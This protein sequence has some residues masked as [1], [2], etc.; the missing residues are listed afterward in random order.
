[1]AILPPTMFKGLGLKLRF[2]ALSELTFTIYEYVTINGESSLNPSYDLIKKNRLISVPEIGWFVIAEVSEDMDGVTNLK[3]VTCNSYEYV[4]NAKCINIT[5][6]TYKLY[7]ALNPND[8]TT[9]LGKI[10]AQMPNWSIGYVSSSLYNKYRTFELPSTTIYGFLM[11][12]AEAAYECI[13]DFDTINEQIRVYD[14]T[15]VVEQT[16]IVFTFDNLLKTANVKEVSDDII[17]ALA[18]Y[19]A[20][21]LDIRNVNPIG[22]AFLYN[23][24][25]YMTTDWMT[26]GLIDKLTTWQAKV[27]ADTVT[28]ATN[29]ASLKTKNNELLQL[30]TEKTNLEGQL[31]A[32]EQVRQVKL[33]SQ[34]PEE[35]ADLARVTGEINTKQGEIDAKQAEI[36]A[37]QA[38]ITTVNNSLQSIHDDL[39]F[40]NN[41]TTSEL[42]ELSKFTFEGTFQN[43]NYVQTD[44]M[45]PAEVQDMSL[46]L[47][48][49]GKKTL[50]KLSQ[51]MYSFSMDALSF[52]LNKDYT[53]FISDL[54]LGCLV[55]AEIKEGD[56]TTPILLEM[57][58]EYDNPDNFTMTFGNRFRLDSAE[59]TFAELYN[60]QA[61]SSANVN[62]Y[63]NMWG[64]PVKSGLVDEV[65][66]YMND[67]LSLAN[68]SIISSN[69]EDI[70]IADFGIRGAKVENGQ[71]SNN[72]IWI[73]H[74]LICMT[75]D[76]WQT[77]K[78]AIGVSEE[79]K[80]FVNANVLAGNLV[81]GNE[82]IITNE[83]NNLTVDGNGLVIHNG[84]TKFTANPND[85]NVIAIQKNI[86]TAS[87][88]DWENQFYT[89]ANG[90]A[91][92]KGKVQIQNDDVQIILD[93]NVTEN[94]LSISKNTGTTLAP[95]WQKSMYVTNDGTL[96]VGGWS[97]S[98]EGLES[99]AG[100]KIMSDGTGK[101]SLLTYT[102]NSAT[103]NGNIYASNLSDYITNSNIEDNSI[104]DSKLSATYQNWKSSV[105]VTANSAGATASMIVQN[106]GDNS[107]VTPATVI[108][109]INTDGSSVKI[110]ADKLELSG[111]AT[112]TSLTQEGESSIN[113]GNI[114]T[115]TLS[116]DRINFSNTGA[117]Q[118]TGTWT[119]STATY[120]T[121]NSLWLRSG[122]SASDIITIQHGTGDSSG[123]IW[124]YSNSAGLRAPGSGDGLRVTSSAV[125]FNGQS[126]SATAKFV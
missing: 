29:L 10:I 59:W 81:A 82:L 2:N 32:L 67:N 102:T 74:N 63:S 98:D 33:P 9:L 96:K 114:V 7:N 35:I 64:K 113:G 109:K 123:M 42:L 73:S 3:N 100:D 54:K 14:T 60:Q 85:T 117:L 17:T 15:D 120:L 116:A 40:T 65:S 18:V 58:I 31:K 49:Q 45:T 13:F 108:A 28:Y 61:I 77:S 111:Y 37:K 122:D 79:G 106:I 43:S 20:D 56:W 97:I 91:F 34:T 11:S 121:G 55:N 21:D 4:F 66:N 112:F 5:D 93:P 19:G 89:D 80:S 90:N 12:T 72:Q 69:G 47:L 70:E 50:E 75:D 110:S 101:I 118:V 95:V 26:Q 46:Q 6:G 1:M 124:L 36:T 38:E 16:D 24:S 39:A 104:S 57:D 41:F 48:E 68:Q 92:F 115:N 88:P 105:T 25:Y 125:T 87:D 23:Y 52:V 76:N 30:Q 44:I 27:T 22:N 107:T 78:M 71:K 86:G 51:P 94:S 8:D 119:G 53:S 84:T 99:D 62:A 126:L 103:F 83:D